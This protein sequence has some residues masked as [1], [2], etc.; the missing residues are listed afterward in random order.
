[1]VP[2]FGD[3]L[4]MQTDNVE[5]GCAMR[6]VIAPDS[7]KESLDAGSVAEAIRDGMARVWPDADFVMKPM[8]D[9][10]EGTVDAIVASTGAERRHMEVQGPTGSPVRAAWAWHAATATATVELAE[11]SG[12]ARLPGGQRDVALATTFGTGQLIKAALDHGARR[13]VVGLGGSATNDGG[14]GLLAAL[15]VHFLD[16]RGCALPP[17]GLALRDLVRLDLD[18]L[19]PRWRRTEIIIASDVDNPLCGVRGASAVFGPQKGATPHMIPLLDDALARLAAVHA[20]QGGRDGR[21]EPG[22]GA[23]GGA[24]WALLSVLGGRVRPGVELVAEL[25]GLAGALDGAHWAVTGE[26]RMDAQTLRGKVPYGVT[27]LARARGVPVLALVGSLGDGYK[28]MY[29]EGMTAAF[30]L[31]PGPMAL[32]HAMAGAAALLRDRAEDAARLIAACG[33]PGS[34]I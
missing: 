6:I 19:D 17:G 22:A 16:A 32:E 26:G 28:G 27:R 34:T 4:V 8:A 30:S 5:G 33:C 23:A 2:E 7:F 14:A 11:A 21:D 18:G 24:G 15:G 13:I 1:M 31:V 3:G 9:G 10:G 12:L 20:A 25:N 29:A